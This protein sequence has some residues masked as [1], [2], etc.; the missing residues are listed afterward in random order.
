MSMTQHFYNSVFKL[1]YIRAPQ[2]LLLIQEGKASKFG[3]SNDRTIYICPVYKT[4]FRLRQFVFGAQLNTK[5]DP[6]KWILA[7]VACILDVE[8][9]SEVFVKPK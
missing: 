3:W 4:C 9:V 7:G 2:L 5:K 6:R 8:G 1:N